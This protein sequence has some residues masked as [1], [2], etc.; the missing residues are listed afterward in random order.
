VTHAIA[1]A[2]WSPTSNAPTSPGAF[3][4]AI[5]SMSS[6][7][8]AA[9]A[10]AAWTTGTTFRMCAR[11]A[12]SGTTPPYRSCTSCCDATTSDRTVVPSSTIAAAVSSHELSS[13]RTRIATASR[14]TS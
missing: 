3:V 7:V 14:A 1:F 6:S 2:V 13:P 12:S 8:D 5:P 4:T 11:D 9:F 10:S